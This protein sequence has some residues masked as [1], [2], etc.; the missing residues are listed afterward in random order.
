MARP[1]ITNA[2]IFNKDIMVMG[3]M[4]PSRIRGTCN[5]CRKSVSV[6]SNPHI[7]AAPINPIKPRITNDPMIT[8]PK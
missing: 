4:V 5:H 3:C 2:I 8:K 1:P 7:F 6:T